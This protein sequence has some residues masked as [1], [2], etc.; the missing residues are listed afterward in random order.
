MKAVSD[1]GF[2][3]ANGAHSYCVVS[4]GRQ[5]L[6]E[7]LS[8]TW[9]LSDTQDMHFGFRVCRKEVKNL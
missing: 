3:A 5:D 6:G 7:R 2:E 8:Y 4:G 1:G 9:L